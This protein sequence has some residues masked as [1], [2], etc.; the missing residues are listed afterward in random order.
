MV[1]VTVTV[2]MTVTMTVM[3]TV[4][5]TV[6]VTGIRTIVGLWCDLVVRRFQSSL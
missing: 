6:T 3:V 4:T 5:V 1:I 2:I